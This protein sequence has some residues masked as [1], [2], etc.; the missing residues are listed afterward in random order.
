[1]QANLTVRRYNPD[2]SP[3]RTWDQDYVLEVQDTFTVLDALIQ[4][5]EEIDGT[6][7]LRCACRASICGSCGM[8]V[9]GRARLAC[10]TRIAEL[11]PQ[12]ERLLIEPMGNHGVIKDLVVD[13]DTF[14]NQ[15]RRVEPYLKP[16][17]IP[18]QAQPGDGRRGLRRAER[19]HLITIGRSPSDGTDSR[20]RFESADRETCTPDRPESA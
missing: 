2:E 7:A 13:I 6:L 14:F 16:D 9:N 18:E 3:P 17:S 12:G 10:K 15:I 8:R 5:R 11:A 1:M 19:Y 20:I 4:I